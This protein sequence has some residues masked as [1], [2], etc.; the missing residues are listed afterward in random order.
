MKKIKIYLI[1]ASTVF[2]T[3]CLKDKPNSDFSNVGTVAEISSSNINSSLNAPSSGLDYFGSATLPVF[4]VDT[5]CNCY[6][7]FVVTFDV[8]ITGEFPPT[9]DVAVKVAIDDSKRTTYNGTGGNQ[10]LQAPDSIYKFDTTSAIV[11]AGS[12][13]AKFNVTFYPDK[14]DPTQSYMLPITLTDA[15]GLTISG[16][17][18]TI[19]LHIIGNPLAGAYN[20]DWSRW[21]ATDSTSS[22]L[23]GSFTAE[24]TTF[25]PVSSTSFHVKTGYYVQPDYLV[26]FTN[27]N[28]VLTDFK[29]VID[30]DELK[31]AFTANGI[32]VV[33]GPNIL[34]ADPVNKVFEFQYTVFN[35]SANRY[36]KDKFYK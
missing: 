27:N 2:A 31:T 33:D 6:L 13:L 25:V 15:S 35:G 17:L 11:K 20:W 30:P 1:I 12:R 14:I 10:Y 5:G 23:V 16:N 7:P 19:Y 9:K 21:N 4:A 26:S 24:S 28:G 22:P 32:T 29:V 3:A 36:I 8:N 34:A 18:S